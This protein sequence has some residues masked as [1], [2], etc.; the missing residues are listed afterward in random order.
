MRECDGF[1]LIGKL[2]G[3]D[4]TAPPLQLLRVLR[5]DLLT[6]EP[7]LGPCRST[8]V[9]LHCSSDIVPAFSSER[10]C[11]LNF[12]GSERACDHKF[13]QGCK[14]RQGLVD[15]HD[16]VVCEQQPIVTGIS[17]RQ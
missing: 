11:D 8:D 13:R 12:Q 9:V 3:V 14:L 2:E 10:A 15:L 4:Q 6:C 7:G 16:L 5:S 17:P 1:D